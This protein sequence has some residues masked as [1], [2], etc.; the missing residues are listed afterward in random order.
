VITAVPQLIPVTRP[1]DEIIGATAVLLLDQV[2]PDVGSVSV[3]VRPLHMLVVPAIA[4]GL[5]YTVIGEVIR[6]PVGKV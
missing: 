3:V 2:P 1:S 4:A 6:Q 5:G